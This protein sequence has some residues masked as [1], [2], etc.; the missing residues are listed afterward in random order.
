MNLRELYEKLKPEMYRNQERG[1]K[2][3]LELLAESLSR[4]SAEEVDAR[5]WNDQKFQAFLKS[6]S[7]FLKGA[8]P[9]IYAYFVR[10]LLAMA[11]NKLGIP[12]K[13]VPKSFHPRWALSGG[14]P[15]DK[16]K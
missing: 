2:A 16:P 13:G 7:R 12:R 11:T 5:E 9:K 3:A 10:K 8:S 4:K 6:N 1:T 14:N 15:T